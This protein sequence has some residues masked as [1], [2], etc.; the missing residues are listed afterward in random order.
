VGQKADLIL[1]DP[2]VNRVIENKQSLYDK[3]ELSG[4]VTLF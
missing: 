1:F 3:E 4:E 2:H